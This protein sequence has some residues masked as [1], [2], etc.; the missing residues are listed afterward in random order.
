[1]TEHGDPISYQ[2]LQRGTP[3]VSSDTFELGTVERV[4]D[5]AKEHIFDGIVMRTD[6]GLL[7]VDAP[8]VAR[9]TERR[10][11]LTIDAAAAKQQ[12]TD[13]APGAPEYRANVRGGRL[14]RFFGG[15]WKRH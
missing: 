15:G 1:V 14:G 6:D 3:V 11:T 5:N 7:W 13:Y 2:A 12:L 9:I 10:V 8:E 4:I